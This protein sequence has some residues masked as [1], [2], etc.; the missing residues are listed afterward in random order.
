MMVRRLLEEICDE[1][2]AAGANLH[3]RLATLRSANRA[4]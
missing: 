4:S 2:K 3:Q 1:N